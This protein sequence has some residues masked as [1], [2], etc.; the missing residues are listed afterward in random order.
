M[1][2]QDGQLECVRLLLE[3]G[4]A[5]DQARNDGTTPLF[6]ACQN[7]H[8]EVAK[9]LSS[10]GASRAATP[11]GTP[12]EAAT[13]DGHADLAAWLVASR[14]WTPLA[15]LE[16]LTAARA[17]SLLRSGASLHEGEPTPLRRAAGGAGEAAALV[18]RAATPW[19]PASHS[20]F[21]AAARARAALLVLSLYEIHERYHLDSAGA[22]N[23]I[24]ALD[25]GH[26]VLGFAIARETQ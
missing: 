4:A 6:A 16:T 24:A 26:C 11:F 12:E 13:E 21:P 9:L 15:H 17:T 2:C 7:G 3:A 18:R 25:F 8:L 22:T 10:Y 20:L 19:S 23:G 1:A 5:I 14:G